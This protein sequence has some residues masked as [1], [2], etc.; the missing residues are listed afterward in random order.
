MRLCRSGRALLF[1]GLLLFVPLRALAAGVHAG[2]TPPITAVLENEEF[3][4]YLQ[5]LEA[6]RRST[7]TTRSS[8]T[9]RPR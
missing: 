6:G 7:A 5:V 9:T 8:C 3:T 4:L 1:M 2:L